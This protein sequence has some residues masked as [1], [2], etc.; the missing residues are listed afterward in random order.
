MNETTVIEEAGTEAEAVA[1]EVQAVGI[2]DPAF[3]RLESSLA[4]YVDGGGS[5]DDVVPGGDS[6]GLGF[7]RHR[8][9]GKSLWNRYVDVLRDEV[10]KPGGELNQLL[11]AGVASSGTVVV[12]AIITVLGI[13]VVAAPVVAP[14]AG[15]MLA[16][17]LKA[18]CPGPDKP[19]AEAQET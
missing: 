14:V 10:C 2:P 7:G 6:E 1:V 19:E 17:G 12:T 16:L 18:F 3:A 9:T 11:S 8:G 5:V 15:V 4:A 13:S